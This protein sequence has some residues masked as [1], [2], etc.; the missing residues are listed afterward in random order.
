VSVVVFPVLNVAS[1]ETVSS[2]VI[3]GQSSVE[4]ERSR[5]RN[6]RHS[7]YAES[8]ENDCAAEPAGSGRIAA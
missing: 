4:L 2:H 6:A 7:V 5:K 8:A 1:K 3:L